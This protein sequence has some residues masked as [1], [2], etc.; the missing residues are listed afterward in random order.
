[1]TSQEKGAKFEKNANSFFVWLFEEI[2][3]I[4]AKDRIQF[5]GTQDGFDIHLIVNINNFERQIHIECKDYKTDLDVGNIL[6]KAWDLEKNYNLTENDLFIAISPRSNFKNADNSE[7]TSPV[8]NEKFSFKSYLLDKSNGIDRL[9]A[10]NDEYY[11]EIYKKDID[12]TFDRVK[13][14]EVFKSIIFSRKPFKKI[15]LT[16]KDRINFIGKINSNTNYLTRFLTSSFNNGE[17]SLFSRINSNLQSL[18]D[19]LKVENK[20]LLL[21]NPGLGK[22]TELKEFAISKWIIG[23][24]DNFLPIFRN[25]KNFTFNS[26]IIDFLPDNFDD[27]T[28]CYI[29]FDGIDEIKDVQDFI[30]K[31]EVFI[32]A[33]NGK[34]QKSI[35]FLLSCRTN[36]YASIVKTIN[37]FKVLYLSDLSNEE[38]FTLLKK[39]LTDIT[40]VDRLSFRKIHYDFLKNPFL[41]EILSDYINQNNSLPNNSIQL[42]ENYIDKRLEFDKKNK[43]IKLNLNTS[44]IVKFSKKIALISELMKANSIKEDNIFEL[45]PENMQEYLKSPLIEKDLNNNSWNFEHRNIQEFFAARYLSELSYQNI[46]EFISISENGKRENIILRFIRRI[47]GLAKLQINKTHPSLF[48][49]ITF[50]I[51]ILDNNKS[52]QIIEWLEKN[53]PEILFTADSDRVNSKVRKIVFQ[54]YFKKTCIENTFWISHNRSFSVEAIAKFG[55][56]KDNFNYLISIIENPNNHFR[57]IISALDLLGYMSLPDSDDGGFQAL[58]LSKLK[59]KDID[60]TNLKENDLKIKSHIIT[61]IQKFNFQNERVEYLDEI[62]EF[63]KDEDNKDINNS[64]LYLINHIDG[65][66]DNY[67]EFIL[68][69]FLRIFKINKRSGEDKYL[70]S[71]I[72]IEDIILRINDS[73]NFIK[74]LHYILNDEKN[75]RINFEDSF[76][77]QIFEKCRVIASFDINFIDKLVELIKKRRYWDLRENE[78]VKLFKSTNSSVK[79]IEKTVNNEIKL[80]DSK[81]LIARLLTN[82]SINLITDKFIKEKTEKGEVEVFRNVIGNTNDRNLALSFEKTMVENGYV[83]SEEY[84]TDEDIQ[85][86]NLNQKIK[87]QENF[88]LLFN[89]EK[90]E[91][92]IKNIFEEINKEEIDWDLICKYQSTWYDKNGHSFEIDS[93]LAFLSHLIRDNGALSFPDVVN[94]IKDEYVRMSE[95]RRH[96]NKNIEFS[97]SSSQQNLIYDWCIKSI[98]EIDYDKIILVRENH[99]YSVFLDYYVC[100]NIYVFQKK[101]DFELPQKFYSKTLKYCDL[102]SFGNEDNQF[103][104]IM[105]KIDNKDVFDELI[106]RDIN[107]EDLHS[108][109]LRNH[110]LYAIE[111]NLTNSF[112]KIKEFLFSDMYLCYQN[113]NLEKFFEKTNDV[114]FLKKCCN[115]ISTILCWESIKILIKNGLEKELVIDI[116]KRYL[117]LNENNYRMEALGILFKYNLPE[118]MQMFFD[119]VK[120]DI[121][122]SIKLEYYSVYNNDNGIKLIEPFYYLLYEQNESNDV[123]KYHHA[124]ELYRYY[125]SVVSGKNDETFNLIQGILKKIK[126]KTKNNKQEQFYINMLIEDSINSFINF[127]SK[128]LEFNNAKIKVESF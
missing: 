25:L 112:K 115:D 72:V 93:S 82:D 95:L 34:E 38:A 26:E 117:I 58:L 108:T 121:G 51:N 53:D 32:E 98:E 27:I 49:T 3:F 87:K 126:K 13:E 33:C 116:G 14:L 110:I 20:V 54:N 124:K 23:E 47:L 52:E 107:N 28:S 122:E 125:L 85:L 120:N 9:F 67:F 83:F 100:K 90:L 1:M 21:G 68:N 75:Y 10:L 56:S 109:S 40:I 99:N 104:F 22:S 86:I 50:L 76:V 59:S 61:C 36:I 128:P 81:Y 97:I 60:S 69:E 8:L 96:L 6:K 15:Y 94:L 24:Q 123:L 39:Q 37:D 11:K 102:E 64:L 29:I 91:L 73:E 31:L 71:K 19:V 35:K 62:L 46:I 78:L 88:D 63:F 30:S 66:I 4:V 105:K 16:E 113:N 5:S 42:W 118:A 70:S 80:H 92:E 111:N 41:V 65:D 17:L 127:K 44:L 48:N 114:E 43:L 57:V 106:V 55:D 77:L 103:D 7:K 89:L 84:L 79:I 119:F 45:V 12:F 18:D 101:F 2:G 74:I